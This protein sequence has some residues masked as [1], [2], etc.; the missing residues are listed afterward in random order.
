MKIPLTLL[1][2]SY[3]YTHWRQYPPGTTKVYSYLESRGG[4]F[5]ET[6]FA[7]LQPIMME[8]L[9]GEV[10]TASDVHDMKVL[11]RMHFGSDL[12]NNAGWDHILRKHSGMLPVSI[13]ALPE[14]TVVPVHNALMTIENTC[15]DCFW[16]TNF[17]ETLLVQ[18]WYPITVATLSR[19]CKRIIL[20]YLA[21]TG[22]PS[23]IDFKLH[24]FG[25]RGVSSVESATLGGMAHLINFKGTDT[26]AALWGAA[27]YYGEE[28]A[29]FSIPASEHSTITSWGKDRE[30]D[31]FANMLASYTTGFVACVSDSFDIYNAVKEIWGSV[32]YDVV[33]KRDGTLVVRPD[34]GDP[35]TVI[36]ECLK[37]LGDA[38]GVTYNDKGYKV[39]NPHVR[40]IQGDGVNIDSIADILH[41]MAVHGWSADNIAFGMGGALLQKLDRDTQKMA[42][43]CSYV[44]GNSYTNTWQRDVF[45]APVTDP[46]K[47][48]KRG[49]LKVVRKTG[50]GLYTQPAHLSTNEAD[51]LVEVFRDGQILT[52]YDFKSIRERTAV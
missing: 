19:E 36:M 30:A 48:S 42:F 14:G 27:K 29:G 43:K 6:V 9:A 2:D 5:A 28:C 3:K 7:G 23:L 37:L 34:S 26:V 24:D 35:K 49:R 18:V 25:F 11:M 39:L 46:G 20:K 16:V 13:K 1:S 50:G 22:D 8:Y 40:L 32:L 41:E 38:F 12:V 4:K 52:S 51:Q 31:A 21:K 17:L 44:E 33:S 15:P 10:I 47:S 45:K